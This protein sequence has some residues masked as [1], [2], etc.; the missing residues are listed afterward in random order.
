MICRTMWWDQSYDFERMDLSFHRTN[1]RLQDLDKIQRLLSGALPAEAAPYPALG[2]VWRPMV[3]RS[4]LHVCGELQ[5][6]V[7][8]PEVSQEIGF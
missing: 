2:R 7:T 6:E 4:N 5:K 8:K 3:K 1:P